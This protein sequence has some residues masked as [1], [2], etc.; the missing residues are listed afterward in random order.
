MN[1]KAIYK[2]Y[3]NVVSIDEG[4]GCYD[5][6]GNLVEIDYDLINSWE[7]PELYKFLRSK[8]YPSVIEQL[9]ILYHGGY[10]AWK[11]KIDEVKQKFPKPT[12]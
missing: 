7:D 10:D 6:N 3:P 2:L 5:S 9:D 11:S 1:H 8:E 4:S 12:E